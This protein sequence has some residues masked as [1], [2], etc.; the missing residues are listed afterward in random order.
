MVDAGMFVP[1]SDTPFGRVNPEAPPQT[2]QFSFMIGRFDCES[3]ARNQ[4]QSWQETK[5]MAWSA[6]YYLNGYGVLDYSS[7][8]GRTAM[9]MR[10]YDE[11]ND[12]WSVTFFSA[13]NFSGTPGTWT[14]GKVGDKMILKKD[15]KSPNGNEGI[16]RLT[17]Y[18]IR[19]DGYRWV[20][21]WV[22]ADSSVVFPFWKI[23][24]ERQ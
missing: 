8:N 6:Q 7:W 2:D 23:D 9:S 22:S 18:D 21:E 20:G 15:Q 24:C 12:R 11:K 4:D 17:F 10:L 3:Q 19:E 16:S 1:D 14:G 5:P 13:P